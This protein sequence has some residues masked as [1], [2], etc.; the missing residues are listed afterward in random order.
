MES[1]AGCVRI[2]SPDDSRQTHTRFVCAGLDVAT[3]PNLVTSMGEINGKAAEAHADP[4]VK[5]Y[6]CGAG[7]RVPFVLT[8]PLH[9][10][11][12]ESACVSCFAAC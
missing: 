11:E 1:I 7:P 9:D 8:L 3:E 5:Y 10:V 12:C 2:R 6:R 4:Y